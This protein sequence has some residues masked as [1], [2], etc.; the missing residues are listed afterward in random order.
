MV[1]IMENFI[2]SMNVVL[3]LF[4]S[5]ALGY[6]LK[7]TKLFDEHSLKV[8]N[9]SVFKIFLPTMLFYNI[10]QT[11]I[12]SAF[13]PKLLAFAV[14]TVL[15]IFAVTFILVPIWEKDNKKKGVLIQGI[16]R[17][18]F[19]IFGIPLIEA[20]YGSSGTGVA[21]ILIAVVV[22]MYNVMAVTSL[23]VFL[24]KTID[25]KKIVKNILTNPLIIAS[26]IGLTVLL[27]GI[28]LPSAVEKTVRD[29]GNV[30]TPL[31]LVVL[32]ASF[33]FKKTAGDVKQIFVGVFGR[34]V[35]VPIIFIPIAAYFGFRNEE[36]MA[37]LAMYCAPTAVSSFTMAQSMGSDGDLAAA[38]LVY[39]AAFSVITMFLF[40][41]GCISLG[42]L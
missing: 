18:N 17:S 15:I 29:L 14:V 31:A 27:C 1:W 21:A 28:K 5:M 34:L 38:L 24:G 23:S 20:M 3:P 10:Y 19:I 41:Y 26:A 39:G 16:F 6:A 12:K 22:P 37:L 30:A 35:L 2:I 11:D 40:T 33:D 25:Y 8:M 36:M 32:G 4:L 7:Y 9:N 13:N 42:W